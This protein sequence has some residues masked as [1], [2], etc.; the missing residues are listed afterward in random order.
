VVLTTTTT[1]S[2]TA[3]SDRVVPSS[4][5]DSTAE[6]FVAAGSTFVRTE[7]DQLSVMWS[8]AVSVTFPRYS[9]ESS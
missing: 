3:T 9:S 5:T 8:V 7:P 6:R 1:V 4:S 2:P